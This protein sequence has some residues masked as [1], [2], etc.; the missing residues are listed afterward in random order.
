MSEA[1]PVKRGRGAIRNARWYGAQ[2]A[3]ALGEDLALETAWLREGRDVAKSVYR[4]GLLLLDAQGL[5]FIRDRATGDIADLGGGRRATETLLQ[6]GLRNARRKTGVSLDAVTGSTLCVTTK[7]TALVFARNPGDDILADRPRVAW[8][9]ALETLLDDGAWAEDGSRVFEQ[10]LFLLRRTRS[11]WGPSW[12]SRLR[13]GVGL[14]I[15]HPRRGAGVTSGG[16][17]CEWATE[18]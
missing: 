7:H 10:T 15:P 6:A 18:Q 16:A 4:C 13:D 3:R 11:S 1:M 2:R 17:P 14:A 12:Q 5:S 8:G 9:A